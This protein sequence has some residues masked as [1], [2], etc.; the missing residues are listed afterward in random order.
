MGLIRPQYKQMEKLHIYS[1]QTF[2]I[3]TR[4]HKVQQGLK[5]TVIVIVFYNGNQNFTFHVAKYTCPFAF[6]F[7]ILLVVFSAYGG[8]DTGDKL[9]I[10][11]AYFPVLA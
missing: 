5:A 10:L 4:E 9:P 6:G 7:L 11:T 8:K 1:R 2:N 3:F